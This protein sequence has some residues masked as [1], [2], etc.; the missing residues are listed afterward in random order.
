[1]AFWVIAHLVH[2]PDLMEQIRQ[3]VLLAIQGNTVDDKYLSEQC[4]KLDSLIGETL[5]LTVASSLARVVTDSCLLGGKILHPGNKIMVSY[6]LDP[7]QI[8]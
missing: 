7:A 6:R 1:M 4:P 2:D 8:D 3:E 5:R